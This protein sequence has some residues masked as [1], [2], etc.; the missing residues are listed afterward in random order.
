MPNTNA[1]GKSQ[2][3]QDCDKEGLPIV[4]LHIFTGETL[5]TKLNI[6]Y[7]EILSLKAYVVDLENKAQAMTNPDNMAKMM[8]G[9]MG[10][11]LG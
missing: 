6:V 2:Y 8:Q 1:E 11:M 10:G 9:F 3:E 4:P 7:R 5:D